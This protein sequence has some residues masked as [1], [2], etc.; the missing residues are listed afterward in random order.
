MNLSMHLSKILYKQ[1]ND[2]QITKID[3]EKIKNKS[4]ANEKHIDAGFH[5]EKKENEHSY[6]WILLM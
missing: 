3:G 6:D 4:G 2:A 5:Y 1:E